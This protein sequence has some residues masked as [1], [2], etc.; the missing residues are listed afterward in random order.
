[1]NVSSTLFVGVKGHVVAVDKNTGQLIWKTQLKSGFL[2]FGDGF[3]TV[4]VEGKRIFA[5][6]YGELF[7]LDALTGKQLWVNELVGFGYDIASLAVE[8]ATAPLLE[9]FV[10]YRRNDDSGDDGD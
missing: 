1:M 7:C 6:S 9:D 8:G 5:H 2:S 4:L 3:V 10:R